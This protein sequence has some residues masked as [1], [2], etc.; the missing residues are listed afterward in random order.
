M[1]PYSLWAKS[2]TLLREKSAIW[3]TDNGLTQFRNM[4]RLGWSPLSGSGSNTGYYN[5]TSLQITGLW[6]SL[7]QKPS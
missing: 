4:E 3:D 1:A 5:G 7:L 2:S 6:L